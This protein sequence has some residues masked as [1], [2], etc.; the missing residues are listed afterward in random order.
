MRN[1]CPG[2]GRLLR[3][4][5]QGWV[6]IGG[7]ARFARP[8]KALELERGKERKKGFGK[9]T[10]KGEW[11]EDGRDWVFLWKVVEQKKKVTKNL[12]FFFLFATLRYAMR[13]L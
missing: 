12:H 8:V 11:E 5:A 3:A 6:R 10:K 2:E 1:A 13:V 4:S 9:K 7:L